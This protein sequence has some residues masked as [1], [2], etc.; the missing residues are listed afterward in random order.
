MGILQGIFEWLPISSEGV[1]AI[2]SRFFAKQ[3]NPVDI[4]IFLHLGTFLASLIYFRKDWLDVLTFKNKALLKFIVISAIV[5]L[6]VGYPVYKI[7][8]NAAIGNSL[9]I[10]TGFGLLMTSYLQKKKRTINLKEN[11]FAGFVGLLQGFSAI[12]GLS[13]SGATIFGLSLKGGEP[14]DILK[15][16]YMMSA[17]IILASSAYFFLKEPKIV[18]ASWPGLFFSLIFGMASLKVLMKISEKSDFSKITFIFAL[19]CFIGAA[20][21]FF[22]GI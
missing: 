22:S 5:S 4:G 17:S 9:L 18:F 15:K 20:I 14:K 2:A 8:R 10:I 12:P 11:V 6:A 16:S 7:A 19:L 13:R 3:F 21:G 1:V